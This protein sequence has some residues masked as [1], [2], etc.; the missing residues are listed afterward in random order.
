MAENKDFVKNAKKCVRRLPVQS[1]LS[2]Y[3]RRERERERDRDRGEGER[4]RGER[5]RQ[6]ETQRE[7]CRQRQ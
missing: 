3:T 6:K 7:T 4:E 2:L 5:G 1:K